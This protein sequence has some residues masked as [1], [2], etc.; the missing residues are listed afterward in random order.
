MDKLH[1]SL[2]VCNHVSDYDE[3]GSMCTV[4]MAGGQVVLD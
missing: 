3:H 1:S 2:S 4:V